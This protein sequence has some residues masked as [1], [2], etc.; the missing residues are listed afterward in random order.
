[1]RLHSIFLVALLASTCNPSA[2]QIQARLANSVAVAGN[3][4]LPLL[5]DVYRAEGLQ[6]IEQARAGGLSRSD[7]EARL[8][9]HVLTWRAVW[10][11]CD[12]GTGA[13]QGG[14]WPSLRAAHDAWA[15]S[16]ERQIAGEPLDLAAVTRHA[17]ELRNAYCQLRAS[18]PQAHRASVPQL[19][20]V[21]CP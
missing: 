3:R 17:S 18:V 15:A 5:L 9:A 11:E 20:G 2:L 6:I 8:Q 21:A 12:E 19:P 1:M 4:I 16:L 10:G 13:C 7:A 14:A